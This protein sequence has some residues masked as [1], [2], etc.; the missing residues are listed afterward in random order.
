MNQEYQCLTHQW[1]ALGPDRHGRLA[2]GAF[3][4]TNTL[5]M[6]RMTLNWEPEFKM[7]IGSPFFRLLDIFEITIIHCSQGPPPGYLINEN[8]SVKASYAQMQQ[9]IHLLTNG[10][11]GLPTDLWVPSTSQVKPEDSSTGSGR[12]CT[13]DPAKSLK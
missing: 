6:W 10:T 5:P 8:L 3:L 1:E 9:Y 13:D 12:N 11:I 2:P 7:N 4:H